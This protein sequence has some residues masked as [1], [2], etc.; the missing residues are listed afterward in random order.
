[1]SASSLSD[2][3]PL[4]VVS[5]VPK[6]QYECLYTANIA[7]AGK[8]MSRFPFLSGDA[9]EEAYAAGLLGL[10]KA[11]HRY[12]KSRGYA[13]STYAGDYIHGHI[14][15]F[16]KARQQARRLP[17]VSLETPIGTEGSESHLEDV[18]ADPASRRAGRGHGVSNWLRCAA[19]RAAG[20]SPGR[21]AGDLRA[22]PDTHGNRRGGRRFRGSY[23]AGA[24][25]RAS[26]SSEG[27]GFFNEG[28]FSRL[29]FGK[30][31][32]FGKRK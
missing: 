27:K 25:K 11:A 32:I 10:W 3:I 4:R 12:D 6:G 16:L 13:F 2:S 23:S 20:S 1:M 24:A 5:G 19:G 29:V 18:I 14:L 9:R 7:L 15:H 21:N 31:W 22:G 30:Q 28:L 26:A 17:T 8:I